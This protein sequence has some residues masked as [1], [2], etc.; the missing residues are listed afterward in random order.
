MTATRKRPAKRS[1]PKPKP[2]I[3]PTPDRIQ[4]AQL[5]KQI[6]KTLKER[7]ER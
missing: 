2:V 6:R 3:V 5:A 7:A 1:G 4:A